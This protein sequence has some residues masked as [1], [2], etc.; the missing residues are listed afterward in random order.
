[1]KN[2]ESTVSK[3]KEINS[4]SNNQSVVN[5]T[6][7]FLEDIPEE[8][9][10]SIQSK[11]INAASTNAYT[12]IKNQFKSAYLIDISSVDKDSDYM[13]ITI[14]SHDIPFLIDSINNELQ[15]YDIDIKLLVHKVFHSKEYA[16]YKFEN[17]KDDKM[18][19]LQF[20]I[21]NWFD[22]NF[23][24]NLTNKISEVLHCVKLAVNDWQKMKG[25]LASYVHHAS[26]NLEQAGKHV[27]Q[28]HIDFLNF[29]LDDNFIFLGY[30]KGLVSE[31]KIKTIK[32]SE[33]LGL[34]SHKN[35]NTE[36]EQLQDYTLSKLAINIKKSELK[37]EVHRKSYM[38]CVTIKSFDQQGNCD[39]VHVFYGF[40]ITKVYYMSVLNIPLIR[41]K[42][43]YV[44]E[45]Y[46]YPKDSYNAK[47]LVT[48]LE[49][50]PRSELLQISNED[51]FNIAAGIVSLTINPRTKLFIR[52]DQDKR[53]VSCL[54]FIPKA[55]FS[56]QI[57]ARIE[58]ILC[59][60]FNG[61]I[62]KYYVKIGEGQLIRLQLIVNLIDKKLPKY[63]VDRVEKLIISAVNVWEDNLKEGLDAKVTKKESDKLF[64]KYQN[65][66][67]V[68]YTNSFSP[69]QSLHDIEAIEDALSQNKVMFKIYNSAKSGK[70]VIQL[71]IFSLDAELALSSIFPVIDN[72]GLFIIDVATF[73]IPINHLGKEQK[74][75]IHY[76]RTRPKFSDLVFSNELR[77]NLEEGLEK[78]WN[79]TIDNDGFNSLIFYV[80][81]NYREAALLRSYAKYLKQIKFEFSAEYI[82][83]T[84]VKYPQITHDIIKLFNI[85]FHPSS[86]HAAEAEENI[87][88]TIRSQLS[89]IAFFVEDKI[90]S[91]YLNLILATKR[92]NFFVTESGKYRDF[93]S[94]KLRSKEVDGMPLPKPEFDTFVYSAQFEAI[95]LR[96]GKVA[97]GGIRWTDRPEDFRKV[98]L[99]LM[100]AQMTKNSLIVPLGCKGGFVVKQVCESREENL[101]LGVKC[102]QNFLRGIMDIT[103]NII[104][105]KVVHPKNVIRYDDND[106]YFVVAADKGTATFSDFAN[107]I[108]KEYN[109]WLGDA[110]ASGGS[111]GYDH[112]KIGI[113]A[114]GAWICVKNH[115]SSMG[116]DLDKDEFTV[117]GIGDMSGDVFGNGMLLSKKMKLVAAFNHMHIFLDPNPNPEVSFKEREWLFNNPQLRWS[118][119]KPHLISQGGGVYERSV[120]QIPI[121]PE[122]KQVLG[123]AVNHLSPSEL[124]TAILKA[125]VD[126]LW[127]GGIGT[128]VKGEFEEDAKIGDKENDNLRI[129]GKQLRCK[130]VGEGGN[131]GFTQQG[132]IEYARN[133][134]RINTDFIDNSGGVDCSDHEVNIKIAL[135]HE[136]QIGSI[137]LEQ[138][139]K[140]LDQLT[141][142]VEELVLKDNEKQS[143]LIDIESSDINKIKD[144]NWF[145]NHLEE[146][147]ELQREVEKLP[148][149]E[150]FIKLDLENKSLTRP[151]IAV[152]ISYA[153]NS[154]AK[155][156]NT[157]DF[158]KGH[159]FQN[160]LISYFPKYLQEHFEKAILSH[161]L[162]NEIITTVISNDFVNMLGCTTFH[163]LLEEKKH[164][165]AAVIQAF[166]I[167]L[168]SMDIR[169]LWDEIQKLNTG[170]SSNIKYKLLLA[171]QKIL[172]KGINWILMHYSD[173]IKINHIIEIYSQGFHDL[174]DVFSKD[175]YLLN[176]V[177]AKQIKKF[178]TLIN[179]YEL[180]KQVISKIAY[181][182]L[183]SSFFDIIVINK[184]VDLDIKHV[185]K[186][187][188][189][190]R[191][192]LYIDRILDLIS[193]NEHLNPIAKLANDYI[194]DELRKF[195]IKITFAQ[196]KSGINTDNIDD[197]ALNFIKD[198]E[199]LHR[200][201]DFAAKILTEANDG[202]NLVLMQVFISK[203]KEL[204]QMDSICS[205]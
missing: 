66:F 186:I 164:K 167:A 159:F 180:P 122:V 97:R 161:K 45:K 181:F 200:F 57:R 135:E 177:V 4:F 72:L 86:H 30:T 41:D 22:Q 54:I 127:N 198:T 84:L 110:F 155:I 9:L 195:T 91:T 128:Y 165:P 24:L 149:K 111:A 170:L 88:G 38:L 74:V 169:N 62:A 168:D 115:F 131:L 12:I 103:D 201:D 199:H 71:K 102:Y 28:E 202:D 139:D 157:H 37:S 154:T 67:N 130:V 163:H 69:E 78:I 20:Y 194:E 121:S 33:S 50:F 42:I 8:S 136:I 119:Y 19:V 43:S 89:S 142:E 196:L 15:S 104:N 92:T 125:P 34:L 93:I 205:L 61:F 173:D 49:E 18:V 63:N 81:I 126:L 143:I 26:Q 25:V 184:S 197:L 137:T 124:I 190:I 188:F 7:K 112:K 35:Y 106:P 58:N 175:E 113:T 191:S 94:L 21:S 82:L 85:R 59:H 2:T 193:R 6:S 166:Y 117:T 27:N 36:V 87:L 144:Y 187:Y 146:S 3:I 118:D 116:I 100:K 31:N 51:L 17:V 75:Y 152:L 29:L 141:K 179:G 73:E 162:N 53:S 99:D 44:I 95:H 76:F 114:K 23:Y 160:I 98:V 171:I 39:S 192:R 132:R 148:T 46:G 64:K 185:A 189:K 79:N 108:S 55:K 158:T 56:T 10:S 183:V 90:L 1:M 13:V 204:L 14:I 178:T 174:M 203:L 40:L 129:L 96:G 138:R 5:F 16:D 140:I 134:G 176:N 120:K 32:S 172:K 145:V 133:G 47:E 11:T 48:A 151:E 182:S 150:E 156:L 65:A 52:E 123:I 70:E 109:F 83:N 101:K 77:V 147:G 107:A 68:K 80:G 105:K 60:Q 153:K